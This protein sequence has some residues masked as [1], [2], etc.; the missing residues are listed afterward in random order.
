MMS[1]EKGK[2]GRKRSQRLEQRRNIASRRT[3]VLSSQQSSHILYLDKERD[4]QYDPKLGAPGATDRTAGIE[5][6]AVR[7]TARQKVVSI[8][9]AVIPQQPRG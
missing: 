2:G 1:S 4:S 8:S 6:R 9:F 7:G 3:S 5:K